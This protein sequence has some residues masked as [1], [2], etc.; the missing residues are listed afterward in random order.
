MPA[1]DSP[2]RHSRGEAQYSSHS[3]SNTLSSNASSSHSDERWFDSGDP[4]GADQDPMAKGGSSD[5]GI[6]ASTLYTPSPNSTGVK[7]GRPLPT[8]HQRDQPQKPIP[9]SATYSGLQEHT[10]RAAERDKR[11]ESS[12]AIGISPQVKGY[13][14]QAYALPGASS[15]PAP[16]TSQGFKQAR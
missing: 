8:A 13:R 16:T 14:T 11:R 10:I 9:A 1:K 12:P 2:N 4:V 7:P 6:D 15:T 5:S 3:S